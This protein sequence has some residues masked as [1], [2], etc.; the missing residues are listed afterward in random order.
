VAHSSHSALFVW[1]MAELFLVS[2]PVAEQTLVDS[3]AITCGV[4]T[5]LAPLTALV[6]L[7]RA[8]LPPIRKVVEAGVEH[9]PWDIRGH[10]GVM[11]DMRLEAAKGVSTSKG[12]QGVLLFPT[13][14]IVELLEIGQVFG[15][16]PDLIVSVAEALYF[17][18]E[19][20]VP[21]LLDSKINHRHKGFPGE[22]GVCLFTSEDSSGIGVF[23]RPE[24]A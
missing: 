19:G 13:H 15:Q 8:V 21:F 14:V 12:S 3:R 17:G 7:L 2:V 18:A 23:P 22:E 4:S 5:P 9:S 24:G 11:K 16:I 1:D 10:R 20:L 6:V